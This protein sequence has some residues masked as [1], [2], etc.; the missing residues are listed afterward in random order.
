MNFR[1]AIAAIPYAPVEPNA[2]GIVAPIM[3]A[4]GHILYTV[5]ALA[6]PGYTIPEEEVL[7]E[8]RAAQAHLTGTIAAVA[9][10]AVS[11][12]CIERVSTYVIAVGLAADEYADWPEDERGRN[13]KDLADRSAALGSFF[14]TEL[15]GL[16]RSDPGRSL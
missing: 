11:T 6:E 14:D 4:S 15:A 13:L 9:T 8:L 16:Y 2:T 3:R 5:G 7:N 10:A 1:E 12:A